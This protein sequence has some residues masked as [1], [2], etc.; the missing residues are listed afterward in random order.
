MRELSNMIDVI[1]NQRRAV[2]WNRVESTHGAFGSDRHKGSLVAP[3]NQP[4]Y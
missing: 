4:L 1:T 2:T 3:Q